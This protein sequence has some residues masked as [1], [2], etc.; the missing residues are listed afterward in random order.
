MHIITI[1]NKMHSQNSLIRIFTY[2]ISCYTCKFFS[3]CKRHSFV[4]LFSKTCRKALPEKFYNMNY[5][6]VMKYH[7]LLNQETWICCIKYNKIFY[8]KGNYPL[9]MCILG[10]WGNLKSWKK[11]AQKLRVFMMIFLYMLS[12]EAMVETCSGMNCWL[13]GGSVDF[14]LVSWQSWCWCTWVS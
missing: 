7:G 13:F 12:T 1:P 5:I 4:S 9:P 6:Q 3:K 2:R 11:A 10:R 8:I 14:L